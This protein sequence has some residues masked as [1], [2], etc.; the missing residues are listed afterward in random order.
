MHEF[1]TIRV[2]Y[3]HFTDLS[4]LD[5]LIL[6]TVRYLWKFENAF[7]VHFNFFQP[8]SH[9]PIQLLLEGLESTLEKEC[10]FGRKQLYSTVMEVKLIFKRPNKNVNFLPNRYPVSFHLEFSLLLARKKLML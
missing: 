3:V 2:L 9:E 5:F 7:E 1:K 6:E 8:T 10:L 4:E